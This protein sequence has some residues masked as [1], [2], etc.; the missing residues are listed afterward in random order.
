MPEAV[1][2][3]QAVDMG[4]DIANALVTNAPLTQAQVECAL[5]HYGALEALLRISGP[6]F[7]N[8]RRD[9]AEYHN[10]ALDR[11]RAIEATP[12]ERE[13]ADRRMPIEP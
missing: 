5:R 8:H 7:T 3:H 11:L 12:I 4:V 1:E 6:R 10:K 2:T 9:A 13:P